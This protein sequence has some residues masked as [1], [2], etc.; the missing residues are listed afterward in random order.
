MGCERISNDSVRPEIKRFEISNPIVSSGESLNISVEL[1]DNEDLNQVRLRVRNAFAKNF[2]AWGLVRIDDISGTS[3]E[4]N[5][6]FLVPDSALSGYYSVALQVVDE[7]GN[8][9][10]DS[11]QYF[12][13][14]REGLAPLFSHF[15]TSPPFNS[16]GIIQVDSN[17]VLTF[18]GGAQDDAG[19]QLVEINLRNEMGSNIKI[20]SYD[21]HREI[22]TNWYF[23]QQGDTIKFADLPSI[24]K[25]MVVRLQDMQGH[26]TRRAFTFE[27]TP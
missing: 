9:S 22:V 20:L 18:K 26:Q 3:F 17:T 11:T 25:T 8:S 6:M 5:Y 21:I 7:R 12:T 2:G 10:I 15:Q 13:I 14:S 24:P 16:E 19:I 27:H 4:R 23:A 1:S